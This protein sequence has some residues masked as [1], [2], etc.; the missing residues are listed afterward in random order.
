MSEFYTFKGASDNIFIFLGEHNN[1]RNSVIEITH[2]QLLEPKRFPPMSVS[3][4][5]DF[6]KS[7]RATSLNYH[8]FSDP[9]LLLLSILFKETPNFNLKINQTL[10]HGWLVSLNHKSFTKSISVNNID[11]K[12]EGTLFLSQELVSWIS[13]DQPLEDE[14]L[15]LYLT[16]I[17]SQT[18]RRKRQQNLSKLIMLNTASSNSLIT[19]LFD[20]RV[21]LSI[22][23]FREYKRQNKHLAFLTQKA[24]SLRKSTDEIGRWSTLYV[25]SEGMLPKNDLLYQI[26]SLEKRILMKLGSGKRI[27][28]IKSKLNL[29]ID[30]VG[31]ALYGLIFLAGENPTEFYNIIHSF[32]SEEFNDI[33]IIKKF[34]TAVLNILK[35]AEM[36]GDVLLF[37][38]MLCLSTLKRKSRMKGYYN[39]FSMIYYV[40]WYN[41]LFNYVNKRIISQLKLWDSIGL[42]EKTDEVLKQYILNIPPEEFII[43]PRKYRMG[44]QIVTWVRAHP[45]IK[46]YQ[47]RIIEIIK[48][49]IDILVKLL[50]HFM[51]FENELAVTW[52]V[53]RLSRKD[54][55]AAFKTAN[56]GILI[57]F[58]IRLY[59]ISKLKYVINYHL[60]RLDKTSFTDIDYV[61]KSINE[62]HKSINFFQSHDIAIPNSYFLWINNRI[63]QRKDINL[64]FLSSYFIEVND[65]IDEKTSNTWL[66]SILDMLL[67]NFNKIKDDE[68]F[69]ELILE[70]V[71]KWRG[72]AG[73]NID[74]EL[75]DKIFALRIIYSDK[76]SENKPESWAVLPV[77]TIATVCR[78][79]GGDIHKFVE[80]NIQYSISKPS[81]EQMAK[82]YLALGVMRPNKEALMNSQIRRVP[83]LLLRDVLGQIALVN[84]IIQY[85]EKNGF[86][87]S[88]E[89]LIIKNI[90]KRGW[91]VDRRLDRIFP[92]LLG[93][94]SAKLRSYI[95]AYLILEKGEM[96]N[97]LLAL[98]RDID[99]YM[100]RDRLR[101][102][103]DRFGTSDMWIIL[104]ESI[105]QD[106]ANYGVDQLKS[107]RMSSIER[108]LAIV[109]LLHST[110]KQLHQLAIQWMDQVEEVEEIL[111]NLISVQAEYLFIILKKIDLQILN[112]S[113]LQ[114]LITRL[115]ELIF[116]PRVK[117]TYFDEI[118]QYFSIFTKR[119]E[120]K[121]QIIDILEEL[122]LSTIKF[123][124]D[125]AIQTLAEVI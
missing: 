66:K 71:F 9:L 59:S 123:K 67:P 93:N 18:D 24:L 88:L 92:T 16:N 104:S 110:N 117:R 121:S 83:E 122:A 79:I 99:D 86:T 105:Y 10:S 44:K 42:S 62:F 103:L 20:S 102:S 1:P 82:H 12:S 15:L 72:I 19:L 113:Q 111:P 95:A 7:T 45:V 75:Q 63:F 69:I 65:K 84:E 22:S 31:D 21:D 89:E 70:I 26:L 94:T 107:M 91:N 90:Y 114:L 115:A 118:L 6:F 11:F 97:E 23:I 119:K 8:D 30:K 60:N 101:R 112:P 73:T 64:Q 55:I 120:I 34:R 78:L 100:I 87:P 27:K 52:L 33:T 51:K 57:K 43:D 77:E 4:L 116:L 32:Y 36:T 68:Y 29:S 85:C 35:H 39:D 28:R 5:T 40:L 76:L 124:S 49:D 54:L 17:I 25:L 80:A 108:K 61:P 74:D 106:V 3:N 125:K 58:S 81:W 13:D 48:A 50:S 2:T 96:S 109:Q 41:K 14:N 47:D 46:Y 53:S 37:S 98:A 56:L 38:G